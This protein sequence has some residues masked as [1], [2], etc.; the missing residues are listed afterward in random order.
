MYQRNFR[1][2]Y[3]ELN[4]AITL[5]PNCADNYLAAAKSYNMT[6]KYTDARD[7]LIKSSTLDPFN[8]ELIEMLAYTY[9]LLGDYPEAYNICQKAYPLISDT[10]SFILKSVS[11]VI[12]YDSDLKTNYAENLIVMLE[13]S[14]NINSSS[15]VDMYNLARI[16]QTIGKNSEA[17]PILEK[18][19][20]V[21]ETKIAK[22]PQNSDLSIYSALVNTRIGR[23][24]IAIEYAKK[25]LSQ[26]PQSVEVKYKVA[27]MYAIQK[28]DS[29]AIDF[30]NKSVSIHFDLSEILD[31]D[32]FNLR[33]KPIFLNTIKLKDK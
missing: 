2:A 5:S 26:N 31:I 9:R 27:R 15:Y 30:L 6:G 13:K 20:R 28:S 14:I 19:L 32:F 33:T 18:A 16:Y 12:L 7:A 8:L 11:N 29:T 1:N 21:I 24:P 10:S 17:A 22:D 25:S 3:K 4:E 23:F